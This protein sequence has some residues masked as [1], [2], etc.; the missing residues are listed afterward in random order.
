MATQKSP[1]PEQPTVTSRGTG[2]I[3]LVTMADVT[4]RM[5]VPSVGMLLL[6]RWVDTKAGTKPWFMLI[7]AVL[8][9]FFAALLVKRQLDRIR[10][11]S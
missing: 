5:F 2:S 11:E 6:G 7:G 1:N 4:W 8:G 10:D 3:L 9:G